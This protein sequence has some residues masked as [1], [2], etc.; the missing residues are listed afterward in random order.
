MI[1]AQE[2]TIKVKIGVEEVHSIQS[3]CFKVQKFPIGFVQEELLA[4]SSVLWYADRVSY[5]P[6]I[7]LGTFLDDFMIWATPST[8]LKRLEQS[9]LLAY[10]KNVEAAEGGAV[11][12]GFI[13]VR[14]AFE[15]GIDDPFHELE[16]FSKAWR[17]TVANR[18][19]K[20]VAKEKV[21][22]RDT[23]LWNDIKRYRVQVTRVQWMLEVWA[24]FGG[25]FR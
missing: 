22:S 25:A 6:S 5:Y 18:L 12:V 19:V 24:R 14:V 7:V 13:G 2:H 20:V 1:L 23:S 4:G 8:S 10:S 11:E 16:G 3:V 15:S 17:Q 9:G 21:V